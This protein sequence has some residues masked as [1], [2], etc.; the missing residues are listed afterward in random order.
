MLLNNMIIMEYT[1]P[2]LIDLSEKNLG[3]GA[4]GCGSGSNAF[5]HVCCPGSIAGL[6]CGGGSDVRAS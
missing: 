5:P 6:T 3:Y 1:K 4:E 2:E